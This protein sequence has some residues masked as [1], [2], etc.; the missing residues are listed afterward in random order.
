MEA[1]RKEEED[2]DMAALSWAASQ[3]S[4]TRSELLRDS[5]WARTYRLMQNSEAAYFKVLPHHQ[6]PVLQATVLLA[7]HFP[8]R[9]PAVIACERE[10]CW[11]VYADHGGRMLSYDS[12]E[13]RQCELL[14][15]Y[16]GLQAQAL[17]LPALLASLKRVDLDSLLTNFWDFLRPADGNPTGA[18]GRVTAQYYIGRSEAK[19]YFRVL[20]GARALLEQHLQ[21]ASGLPVTL[22][23]GDLRPPNSATGPAGDC[24]LCDWDDASAGPA[25]LSLHG[26]FSGCFKPTVL[27]TE[28]DEVGIA[29]AGKQ[30]ARRLETYI[31]ELISS[32]YADETTLRR[33]LPAAIC[34]GVLLYLLNFENYPRDD[35]S[36]RRAVERSIKSRLSDLLDLCELLAA[37][38]RNT[39]QALVRHYKMTGQHRRA[40][41]LLKS[42]LINH[43]GDGAAQATLARVLKLRGKDSAALA[44]CRKALQLAPD[45]ADLHDDLG[46]M[47][48]ERLEIDA[49]RAQFTRALAI[50]PGLTPARKH[51][52]HANILHATQC[53]ARQAAAVPTL[54]YTAEETA[55]GRPSIGKLALATSLF[56]TY[57]VLQ[58]DNVFPP[59]M[60][61]RLQDAFFARYTE[62]FRKH[63]H[64]DALRL[65]DQR[66]MLTIDLEQPFDNPEL[67]ASPLILPIFR[68]L[69]GDDC[70]LGAFTAVISLPGAGKQTLHKDT[71]ALFPATQWQH[72]L[73]NFCIQMIVPLV[74]LDTVVGTTRVYKG[75]HT[76]PLEQAEA[77]GGQDPIVPLGSCL[78]TDYRLGHHGLG[79]RSDLVRPILTIIFNRPW[80]RDYINYI[81][82]P[83]LRI[84]DQ[85]YQQLPQQHQQLFRWWLEERRHYVRATMS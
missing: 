26:M 1:K 70:V 5:P 60:I 4:F 40:Q 69:L 3:F 52:D 54:T 48:L 63:D 74:A 6:Q 27:L 59:D 83:P 29:V 45:Q 35:R 68:Q 19:R 71:R 39:T 7:E 78:L 84:S 75:S 14:K 80:F 36:Y 25:G 33:A 77:L 51:L 56:K 31:S 61:Q 58:I 16:A 47:L 10:H 62:Y 57:G 73:P 82:Q 72:A 76:L 34:A 13:T 9:V 17:T 38:Q 21:P 42:Y 2:V 28:T 64:P 41:Y 81:K 15:T 53:H 67:Y 22:C 30:R 18:H 44:A 79:N 85:Q 37:R 49:A 8:D 66:Y 23:H 24:I 43:P 46:Q 65:G 55:A 20:H 50:D 12:A 32:G 11:I